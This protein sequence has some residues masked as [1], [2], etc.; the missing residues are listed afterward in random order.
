MTVSDNVYPVLALPV[1][2]VAHVTLLSLKQVL[3]EVKRGF[4]TW[5]GSLH[6]LSLLGTKGLLAALWGGDSTRYRP[7]TLGANLQ[8]I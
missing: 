8:G 1:N 2:S 4:P 6:P 3:A 5:F 7:F